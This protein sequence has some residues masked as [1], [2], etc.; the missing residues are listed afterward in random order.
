[1]AT[2]SLQCTQMAAPTAML[3]CEGA[4]TCNWGCRA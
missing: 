1:M 2:P 4:P 3:R